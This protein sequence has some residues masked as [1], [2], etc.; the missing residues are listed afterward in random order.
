MTAVGSLFAGYGGLDLAVGLLGPAST[1]WVADIEP[2]PRKT[3]A[4]RFPDAPN[5]GDVTTVDW[6]RVEPVDIIVGGSPC[7][8]LSTAGRRAGMRPGTRSGLWESMAA[9]I[10]RLTPPVVIWENVAGALSAPA[11]SR[12]ESDD[13]VGARGGR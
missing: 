4:H 5:L 3:L 2:G 1:A 10:H 9:A 13:F 8:D 6:G 7:Q 12:S 11:W